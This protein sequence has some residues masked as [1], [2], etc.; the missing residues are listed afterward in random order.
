MVSGVG[1]AD[2]MIENGITPIVN[3]PGVGQNLQDHVAVGGVTYVI[4]DNTDI[5]PNGV[6]ARLPL[7]MTNLART[8]FTHFRTGP[9]Y[10]LPRSEGNLF[11]N[12]K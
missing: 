4:N 5:G 10:S 8:L 7:Y 3:L 11:A 9:L 1:P 12:S 2:H 6:S